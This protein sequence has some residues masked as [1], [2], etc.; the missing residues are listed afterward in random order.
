M[1]HEIELSLTALK[2]LVL[3]DT[4]MEKRHVTRAVERLTLSPLPFVTISSFFPPDVPEQF[5]S[6]TLVIAAWRPQRCAAT[7]VQ[8]ARSANHSIRDLLFPREQRPSAQHAM[9][10]LVGP[11]DPLRRNRNGRRQAIATAGSSLSK[12]GNQQ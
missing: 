5:A 10:L 3:F 11:D 9:P 6:Q 4:V 8:P 2:L 12:K 7:R 1:L